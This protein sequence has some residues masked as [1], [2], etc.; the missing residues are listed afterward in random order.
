M[1]TGW[2]V[3]HWLGV[4]ASNDADR[5]VLDAVSA[6][7]DTLTPERARYVAAF[8]YLLGRVA[9]AD[10]HTS[11]SEV[12]T[13]GRLVAQEGGLDQAEA[14]AVVALALKEHH[15]FGATHNGAVSRAFAAVATPDERMGLIRCLYAV[16]SADDSIS[17][18]EDNEIRRITEELRIEHADFVRARHEVR[19][20]LAVLRAI[21]SPPAGKA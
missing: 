10:L 15:T 1:G 8:A 14:E 18:K 19:Q 5:V 4:K 16:S 9:G 17:V 21:P 12:A 13:M 11:D 3:L 2:N 20:H 7:L 6:E